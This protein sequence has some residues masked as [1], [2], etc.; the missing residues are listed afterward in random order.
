MATNGKNKG[1]SFERKI[2]N[3]LSDR[4]ESKLGIKNG[5]RRNPDSGSFFGG[6]NKQRTQSYSLDYAL[7]GDLICPRNFRFSIECKHYKTP[8]T[9][10][11]LPV[12]F[13]QSRQW[14]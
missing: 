9:L 5:F 4:F 14:Q 11:A 12:V 3:L 10:K 1:S 8:P 6:S 2:A 13:L 7:F